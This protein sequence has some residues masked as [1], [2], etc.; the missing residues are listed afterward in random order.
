M[1]CVAQVNLR[2][3]N[4]MAEWLG[5][6]KRNYLPTVLTFVSEQQIRSAAAKLPHQGLVLLLHSVRR[7]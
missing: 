6:G 7:S 4:P 5:G 1:P 3:G 2:T